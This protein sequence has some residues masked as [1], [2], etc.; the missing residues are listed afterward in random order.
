[1]AVKMHIF[2][3]LGHVSDPAF[4]GPPSTIDAVE[5]EKE[6]FF[7]YYSGDW[8]WSSIL[9]KLCFSRRSAS[10]PMRPPVNAQ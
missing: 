3:L 2:A 1:M 10:A 4:S 8:Q 6:T 5:G 7:Q 9:Q